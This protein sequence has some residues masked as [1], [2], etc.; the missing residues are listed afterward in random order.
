[1]KIGGM[2]SRRGQSEPRMHQE[3]VNTRSSSDAERTRKVGSQ[4][5]EMGQEKIHFRLTPKIV[6]GVAV[7]TSTDSDSE[8]P[9]RWIQ[10]KDIL[11][12]PIVAGV[13]RGVG[14]NLLA[15]PLQCGSFVGRS[16]R[17]DVDDA[18]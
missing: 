10:S 1:M 15:Q 14:A 13:E 5:S 12:G 9:A 8:N 17:N 18:F 2:E 7:S 11:V 16:G 3:D 4:P 6:G